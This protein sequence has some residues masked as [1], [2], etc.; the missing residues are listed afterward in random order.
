MTASLRNYL[1]LLESRDELN[2]IPEPVDLEFDVAAV[3]SLTDSGPAVKFDQPSGAELAVV[4]NVVNSRARIALALGVGEEAITDALLDSIARPIPTRT[5]PAGACQQVVE[6]ADLGALPAPRFF[7]QETGAYITAG[8]VIATDVLT[9][10][11]NMSFARFKLL[12][13]QRAMLGVSPNHHLGKMAQR[14]AAAGQ[15]LPIAVAIGVHPAIMLAGCLYL[16]FG[17]DE[18]ECA[19]RLLGEPVDVV[20]ATAS[21]NLVP[22][23][24]ELVLEG[25]VKPEQRIAEGLVSEF[26]GRYHDYGE[27]YLVEFSTLTRRSD[28]MFQVVM[29]GLHQEHVLLGAVSIAASLRADLQR[30][31]SNVVDVAVPD[32]GAGRTTAVVSVRD[33]QPG[34]ARQI[35]MACFSA[36][37]LIKQVVV[38]DDRIDVWNADAVE[39]ARVFCARPERDYLI[40]PGARTDRSDPLEQ[41]LTIGKLG[42]DATQKPGDRAVGW[43]FAR[44]PDEAAERAAG[45]LARSGIEPSRSR[46]LEGIRYPGAT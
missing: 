36:V 13:G 10:E 38:V 42:V 12:D 17:D 3:L 22:A 40:V 26:H 23:D 32:T 2:T 43:D 25:V 29:P 24:A 21:A 45:L 19:G 28:A 14:A 4:G 46:L 30:V 39:W 8:V 16:G 35:M 37:S 41:N 11:R 20:R 18:L 34:Q 27:G 7:A 44:V 6:K 31:T 33:I 5:L 1:S 9:G 15:D